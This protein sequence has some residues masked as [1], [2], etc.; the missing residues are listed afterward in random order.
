MFKSRLRLTKEKKP[1]KILYFSVFESL[2]LTDKTH[3]I[4][5]LKESLDLKDYSLNKN[6]RI[7]SLVTYDT[8][9]HVNINIQ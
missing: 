4:P 9:S 5:Y 3:S 8:F 2:C 6:L 7:T 1:H